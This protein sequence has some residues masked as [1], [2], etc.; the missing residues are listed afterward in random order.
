[1]PPSLSKMGGDENFRKQSNVGVGGHKTLISRRGVNFL[2]NGS[3]D[4]SRKRKLHNLNYTD[5]TFLKL[6][7]IYVYSENIPSLSL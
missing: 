7:K 6:C 3:K 4:L 5:I 2:G 1:M